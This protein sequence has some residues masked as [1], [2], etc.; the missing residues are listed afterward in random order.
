MFLVRMCMW[1]TL[2]YTTQ[3]H[4]VVAYFSKKVVRSAPK[5]QKNYIWLMRR[6]RGV[7]SSLVRVRVKSRLWWAGVKC[8]YICVK[9]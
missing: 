8:T 2:Q 9:V 1:G 3:T 7:P 4:V 6:A 5:L